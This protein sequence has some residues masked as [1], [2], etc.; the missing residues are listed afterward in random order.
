MLNLFLLLILNGSAAELELNHVEAVHEEWVDQLR[1]SHSEMINIS[2]NTN[3]RAD[4]SKLLCKFSGA[5]ILIG[6]SHGICK[7]RQGHLYA[8]T[9]K[10]VGASLN[11]RAGFLKL[12]AKKG[13]FNEKERLYLRHVGFYF[14]AG[15]EWVKGATRDSHPITIKGWASGVGGGF[16]LESGAV[17]LDRF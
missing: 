4:P 12:K 15:G 7:S 1:H 9:I 16:I 13:F 6:Y 10:S 11:A 17:L 3:D 8:L 14:L 5:S 2:K